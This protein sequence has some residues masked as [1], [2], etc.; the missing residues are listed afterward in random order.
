MTCLHWA[1]TASGGRDQDARQLRAGRPQLGRDAAGEVDPAALPDGPR[2]D[3]PDGGADAGVGITGDQYDPLGV[4][5]RGDLQSPFAQGPQEGR[6]EVDRL[7]V[8]QGHAQDL[9]AALGRHAGG[10]HQGPA[11]LHS[12]PG[13]PLAQLFGVLPRREHGSSS[14]HGFRSSPPPHPGR[15]TRPPAQRPRPLKCA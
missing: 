10:H 14:F 6:P 1:A 9:L 12:H 8:P 15:T 3:D 7:S 2:Q 4:V 5:G 11:G 13:G